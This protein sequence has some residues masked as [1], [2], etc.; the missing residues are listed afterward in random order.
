MTDG[1]KIDPSARQHLWEA[2]LAA[3]FVEKGRRGLLDFLSPIVKSELD[4]IRPLKSAS[5]KQPAFFVS[6]V[7]T[8]E[9]ET[10]RILKLE[11]LRESAGMMACAIL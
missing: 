5:L 1:Y 10:L 11:R 6:K 9:K 4:R 7:S 2:Y 3:L 8:E